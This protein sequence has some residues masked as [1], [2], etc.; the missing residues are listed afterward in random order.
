MCSHFVYFTGG[1]FGEVLVVEVYPCNDVNLN[2]GTNCFA[3]LFFSLFLQSL[4][5]S[6][7]VK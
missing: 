1:N 3:C 5:V 6:D 4:P 2:Q 7:S